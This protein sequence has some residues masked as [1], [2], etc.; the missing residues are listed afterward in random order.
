MKTYRVET[1]SSSSSQPP[2][3]SQKSTNA[4][5]IQF[6]FECKPSDEI[7]NIQLLDTIHLSL[8]QSLTSPELVARFDPTLSHMSSHRFR[9]SE[10]SL[11]Y[12]TKFNSCHSFESAQN[13]CDQNGCQEFANGHP[14]MRSQSM[15]DYGSSQ[16][17]L[18]M[19]NLSSLH[20]FTTMFDACSLPVSRNVSETCS[21][22]PSPNMSDTCS[23]RVSPNMSDTCFFPVSRNPVDTCCQSRHLEMADVCTPVNSAQSFNLCYSP[24]SIQTTETGGY[25]LEFPKTSEHYHQLDRQRS[26]Q[27]RPED[28]AHLPNLCR[29]I[30]PLINDKI[31]CSSDESPSFS[32]TWLADRSN[33]KCFIDQ[34]RHHKGK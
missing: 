13:Q 29:R 16:V 26:N 6:P 5:L 32:E 12:L 15:V 2:D 1:G 23:V 19:S 17:S 10:S 3:D 20:V 27:Y 7:K 18:P 30:L 4:T 14:L 11:E 28:K 31:N 34:R 24:D 33:L 25:S 9:S 22:Q 8:S 21:P